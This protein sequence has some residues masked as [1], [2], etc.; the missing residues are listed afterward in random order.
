MTYIQKKRIKLM[1]LAAG[2]IVLYILLLLTMISCAAAP[3]HSEICNSFIG[4]DYYEVEGEI[5]KIVWTDF[6][7]DY[8]LRGYKKGDCLTILHVD[9]KNLITSWETKGKCKE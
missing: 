2:V 4:R 1:A 8:M 9:R 3:T 7:G 5:G 6:K